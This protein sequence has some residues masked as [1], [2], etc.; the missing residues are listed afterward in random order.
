MGKTMS[1]RKASRDTQWIRDAFDR[2]EG[3]LVRYAVRLTGNLELARDVVQDTFLRL[4]RQQRDRVEGHLAAWL[5]TVCRRRALDVAQKQSRMRSLGTDPDRQPASEPSQEMVVERR[6]S[7]AQILALLDNLPPREQEVVRLKL[8]N[9][10]SYR[11]ISRVT[12]LSVSNV[13]YLIHMAIRKI[14]AMTTQRSE[15][16]NTD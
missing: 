15:P 3:P 2:Y 7:A 12:G 4:C 16:A 11:E 10:L 9:E 13:G 14:R 1:G 8:Q 6:E 5:F